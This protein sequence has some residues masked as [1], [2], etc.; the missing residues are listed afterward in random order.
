MPVR[1]RTGQVLAHKL[2]VFATDSSADQ[3][4]LSS[5]FHQ[6]WAIK[7]G[8]TLESRVNYSPSDVFETFLRPAPTDHLEQI[9]R[10]LDAVRSEIMLHCDLGLAKLYNL[11]NDPDV[12]GDKDVECL[13]DI[14]V[15]LDRAVL[16]A[17]GWSDIDPAHGFHI[18]R[19]MQRR[20]VSPAARIEI[21]D[22]LL[23]EDHRRAGE[24]HR[25]G[26][27][28]DFVEA[29]SDLAGDE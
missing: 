28:M 16:H 21:L 12:Q 15:G 24:Q 19:Q 27:D 26:D 9:G 6:M 25:H 1:V 10:T 4:V 5:T 22:R 8:S 29:I 11:V 20:T 3:A 13:R 23:D 14:H 17:Y 18:Y 2:G 7:F